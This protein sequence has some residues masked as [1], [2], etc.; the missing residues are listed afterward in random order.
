MSTILITMAEDPG[1]SGPDAFGVLHHV[2]SLNSVEWTRLLNEAG[3]HVLWVNWRDFDPGLDNG[4]GGFKRMFDSLEQSF[5]DPLP[6]ARIDLAWLYKME[7][8]LLD[9]PAFFTMV[10]ALEKQVVSVLNSP[11]LIRHNIDKAYLL[12]LQSAGIP[13][14]PSSA[15]RAQAKAWLAKDGRAIAKPW[16]S[17]R[18]L[19]LVLCESETELEALPQMD[20]DYLF[21]RFIP[22]V[23]DG[24]R[25]LAFL[26][27]DYQFCLLKVPLPGDYRTNFKFMQSVDLYE[28]TPTELELAQDSLAAYR[29]LGFEPHYS[30]ID[31]LSNDGVPMLSEAELLNPSIGSDLETD[32]SYDRALVNYLNALLDRS[33]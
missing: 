31:L 20:R 29:N 5:T 1:Q 2:D 21:Q 33:S 8:F 17:E 13:T 30:R 32:G 22:G 25:S 26:G 3:H 16:C 6:L 27:E 28:P 4:A 10:D 11:A 14:V 19:G 7:G 18:G 15:D 12:E 24:E 9:Q 23:S